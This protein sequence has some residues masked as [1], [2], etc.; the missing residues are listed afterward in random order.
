MTPIVFGVLGRLLPTLVSA[1]IAMM[2]AHVASVSHAKQQGARRAVF[3]FMD[4]TGRMDDE[5]TRSHRNG[6]GRRAHFARA[7]KAK[8]DFGGVWMAVIGADLAGLPAGHGEVT[9]CY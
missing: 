9:S 8:V 6:L 4:F 5:G 2:R 7:G 1:P 3:V